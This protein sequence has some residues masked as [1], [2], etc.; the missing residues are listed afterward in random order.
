MTIRENISLKLS[1]INNL[2]LNKFTEKTLDKIDE[3]CYD[4]IEL[5]KIARK[6]IS[7]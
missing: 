7:K 3:A 6:Y 2:L 5:T 1:E 4:I